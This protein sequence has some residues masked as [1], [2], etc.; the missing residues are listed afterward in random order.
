[1]AGK[2]ALYLA[3]DVSKSMCPH[4]AEITG[5]LQAHLCDKALHAG[6]DA[7]GLALMG[8]A[9]TDNECAG[10]P[11]DEGGESY[12]GYEHISVMGAM[13]PVT[14]NRIESV[15]SIQV[16]S[17]QADAI[18][19]LVVASDALVRYVRKLKFAKRIMLISDGETVR[20]EADADELSNIAAQL[21]ENNVR[22]DIVTVGALSR[23]A[24]AADEGRDVSTGGDLGLQAAA[25][26][27]ASLSALRERVHA[28]A[29][30]KG[31][32]T[33]LVSVSSWEQLKAK[34]A[35]PYWKHVRPSASY[36]GPLN[37]SG[38]HLPVRVW[39]KVSG[40]STMP[41][42]FKSISKSA[43]ALVA[44]AEHVPEDKP[45]AEDFVTEKRYHRR[46][47]PDDDVV[48]TS[49]VSAYRYGANLI[50][51][52]GAA[53]D[54]MK[55]GVAEKCFELTGFVPRSA[56]PRHWFLGTA[57]VVVGD[58]DV[59]GARE[60]VQELCIEMD[61][62]GLGAV[63]RYAPRA[64]GAPHLTFLL[65][66]MKGL[67]MTELPF[68]DEL[69]ALLWPPVAAPPPTDQ[70][71]SAAEAFVDALDLDGAALRSLPEQEAKGARIRELPPDARASMRRSKD[72]RNPTHQRFFELLKH[73][74]LHPEQPLPP[75]PWTLVRPLQQDTGLFAAAQPALMGVSQASPVGPM[76]KHSGKR[77][78]KETAGES[79]APAATRQR[80]PDVLPTPAAGLALE[81]ESL[82][83]LDLGGAPVLNVDSGRPVET[84]WQ[85]IG[86]KSA[87]R[88]EE[89][90]SQMEA[91][92]LSLL[93]QA[94]R[95]DDLPAAKAF[96]CLRELR[97]ACVDMDEPAPYNTL[98]D[99]LKA[100]WLPVAGA[101][102]SR[103]AFWTALAADADLSAGKISNTEAEDSH[104]SPQEARAFLLR[105][106]PPSALP[107]AA[108]APP[109]PDE[110]DDFAD[111]E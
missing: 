47:D 58:D 30:E 62:A 57:D 42:K 32:D 31:I 108:E 37:I 100:L 111:L 72:T 77:V 75:P 64:K 24:A 50:P 49:F 86:D 71:R 84:F 55:Y 63:A 82:P 29:S 85:V 52:S 65:P 96:R 40:S 22:L 51:F 92:T 6:S 59:P 70:Q 105:T 14:A 13:G 43:A 7:F 81:V 54:R 67:Y 4:I 69:K 83:S 99:K 20:A 10:A 87:D 76:L 101:A 41:I 11:D 39:K 5:S 56:V 53:E 21:V 74:L 48:P 97:R 110:E 8:T 79:T 34:W 44:A 28:I 61:Q 1:M 25:E 102:P 46:A 35:E 109:A 88:V 16:E 17:G 106:P 91:V 3:L 80:G 93:E 68:K 107:L 23:A 98:L 2:E 60:A 103:E 19:G 26:V 33:R 90:I 36:R 66:G 38:R 12:G 94:A 15:S 18:D 73:K 45:E 95:P 78:F 27:W 89:A 104:V 9:G